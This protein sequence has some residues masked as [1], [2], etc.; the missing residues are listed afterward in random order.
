[1]IIKESLGEDQREESQEES[2]IVK[3]RIKE[4]QKKS[5]NQ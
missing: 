5:M 4:S 3:G 1:M 2:R